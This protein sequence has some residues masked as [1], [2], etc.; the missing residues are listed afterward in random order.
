MAGRL[1]SQ[2]GLRPFNP[3]QNRNGV[4]FSIV[5]SAD[6]F[7]FFPCTTRV[8]NEARSGGY[9][10]Q[11]NKHTNI[12]TNKHPYSINIYRLGKN[13]CLYWLFPLAPPPPPP[14]AP[15]LSEDE[16]KD[17]EKNDEKN[18][19][20]NLAETGGGGGGSNPCVHPYIGTE[21]HRLDHS[22]I[23]TCILLD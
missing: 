6:K 11:T 5:T 2:K 17:Y 14:V 23:R 13:P 4:N 9:N 21:V 20:K 8:S 19:E 18:M 10:H 22:S 7:R 12:H 15:S 1:R 16:K 3:L